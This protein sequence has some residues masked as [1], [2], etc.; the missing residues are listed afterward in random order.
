LLVD[1]G[2]RV[3]ARPYLERALRIQQKMFG[4]QDLRTVGSLNGLG[5]L[6]FRQGSFGD[7]V[8]SAGQLHRPERYPSSLFEPY[9]EAQSYFE[10]ALAIRTK[11]LGER[12][13]ET[14]ESLNNLGRVLAC[15]DDSATARSYFE[16]ALTIQREVLG[17]GHPRTAQTLANL[18]RLLGRTSGG[19]WEAKLNLQEARDIFERT[20][21]PEHP[22]TLEVRS[23]LS[24][25]EAQLEYWSSYYRTSISG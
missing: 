17:E 9:K 10:Q 11:V 18:G 6:L 2:L 4:E 24:R 23:D 13:P 19:L 8:R 25:I 22:D 15:Q 21:G 12:H 5:E 1:Q 7:T 16:R 3:H 20:F 14:A